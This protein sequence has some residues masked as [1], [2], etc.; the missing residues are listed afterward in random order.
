MIDD[1]EC[2]GVG[3]MRIYR[4]NRS[5]RRKPAPLPFCPPQIPHDLG[6]NTGRSGGKPVTNRLNHGSAYGINVCCLCTL[7]NNLRNV[8]FEVFSAVV[9][10]SIMFWDIKPCSPLSF[11]RRFEGTFCMPPARLPF[12]FFFAELIS[13]TLKMEAIFSSETSVETE[14]TIRRHIPEDDTF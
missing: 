1:D 8:G 11:N 4:G 9:M 14:R 3:G 10:K 13:S 12:L 7:L 5:T 2:G 6:S